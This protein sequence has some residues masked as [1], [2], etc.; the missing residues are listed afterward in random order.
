VSSTQLSKRWPDTAVVVEVAEA[1]EVEASAVDEE[2]VVVDSGPVPMLWVVAEE[3]TLA[4]GR[5]CSLLTPSRFLIPCIN[6]PFRYHP[7]GRDPLC[8]CTTIMP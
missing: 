4:D 7:S 6:S 8:M 1:V 3:A 2:V 5:S